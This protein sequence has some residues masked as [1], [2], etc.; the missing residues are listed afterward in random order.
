MFL[1]SNFT[2]DPYPILIGTGVLLAL[3]SLDIFFRKNHMKK[4]MSTDYEIVLVIASAVG[5]VCAILF[6]NLYDFIESPS[7]YQW[8]WGMTFLGGLIGGIITFFVG[9]F[10][11]L[12]KK[13]PHSIYAVAVIEGA[14]IPFAHGFGRIGCTLDGCCY[15]VAIPSDSPFYWMGMTFPET[16]GVKVYP[17]QLLEAIF[18]FILAFVLFYLAFKKKST[19]TFPIYFIS[20]GIFRFMIEFLR[21]DHRGSFLPGISPSQFW[22]LVLFV[23]GIVSLVYLIIKKKI[24][25]DD[26]DLQREMPEKNT[27]VND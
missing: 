27:K 18:L 10:F 19:L 8:N 17:T 25:L 21:G 14:G 5:I 3:L 23:I 15:G 13:Y 26:I 6:Q 9:W 24:S 4:G 20:Y 11:F 1:A 2:F 12:R 16:N 22:S 7:T